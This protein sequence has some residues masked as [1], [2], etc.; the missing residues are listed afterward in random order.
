MIVAVKKLIKTS[1]ECDWFNTYVC[2]LVRPTGSLV[3]KLLIKYL[4]HTGIQP[5]G[6]QKF[7]CRA[8]W[9]SSFCEWSR[10]DSK[11]RYLVLSF[12]STVKDKNTSKE[13]FVRILLRQAMNFCNLSTQISATRP[14][15][16]TE[17]S[18]D[19]RQLL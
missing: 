5:C 1:G 7:F 2:D 17:V 14:S 8:A 6:P 10:R 19:I 16:T 4:P 18:G 15:N 9:P 3:L 13:R 11:P 12:V